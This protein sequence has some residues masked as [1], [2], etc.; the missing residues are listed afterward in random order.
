MTA[1]KNCERKLYTRLQFM[2]L[3]F[4]ALLLNKSQ[5]GSNSSFPTPGGRIG[6]VPS[7]EI[8]GN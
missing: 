6:L 8:C 2:V 1:M 5:T 3:A 4:R 7:Q